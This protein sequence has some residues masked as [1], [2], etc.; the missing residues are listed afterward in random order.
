M[1]LLTEI[2]ISDDSISLAHGF[3]YDPNK[4]P[5]FNLFT[6]KNTNTIYGCAKKRMTF[7]ENS[8]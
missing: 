6:V 4:N 7:P 1:Y 8:V 5:F 2:G 3:L